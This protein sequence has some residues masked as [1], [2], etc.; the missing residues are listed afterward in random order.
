MTVDDS[1]V[2]RIVP[3]LKALLKDH[4]FQSEDQAKREFPGLFLSSS[5]VRHTNIISRQR[6]AP[7]GKPRDIAR[8]VRDGGRKN[9]NQ[10]IP[11]S[12]FFAIL[13]Q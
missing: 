4:V 2:N 3:V 7:P 11:H 1:H 8:T 12:E 6:N 10:R 9:L 13:V 5:P